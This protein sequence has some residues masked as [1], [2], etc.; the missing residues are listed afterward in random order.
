MK[1]MISS[2]LF[3][4]LLGT[5]VGC[6]NGGEDLQNNE[7]AVDEVIHA[8]EV[9]LTITEEVAIDEPVLMEA[10]VSMGEEKIKDADNVVFEVWE[11]GNKD[12]SE[13]IKSVNEKDGK[14]TAETSFD[15]DGLY[16]IQVH[17]DA[18]GQHTMPKSVVT[19]G[20]GGEYESTEEATEEHAGHDSDGFTMDFMNPNTAEVNKEVELLVDIA[21][22]GEPLES[23]KVRYEIWDKND[24]DAKHDWVDT[25]ELNPGEYAVL[26]EF[27]KT[28]TY[29]VEIHVQDDKDLHEHEGHEIEVAE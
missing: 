15:T 16:H 7:I 13:M 20:D 26:F 4:L 1:R 9:E 22:D 19:V 14:Y 5:L 12:A 28:G 10:V 18:R 29:H 17:V 23:A 27:E 11:E 24:N 21:L 3:A 6:S 8:L 2:S 25:E